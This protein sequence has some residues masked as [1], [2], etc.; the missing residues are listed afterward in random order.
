MPLGKKPKQNIKVLEELGMEGLLETAEQL[1]HFG[2]YYPDFSP[3]DVDIKWCCAN[4]DAF[5]KFSPE[6][7]KAF[8]A[9]CVS[10]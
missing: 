2:Y 1:A 6:K 10:S 3:G 8:E 5:D 7:K 9:F 4:K